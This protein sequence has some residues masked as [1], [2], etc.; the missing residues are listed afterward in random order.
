[1]YTVI[2]SPKNRGFRVIWALEEMGL[3]YTVQTD[4]PASQ[5]VRKFNPL[6]KVPVLLDGDAVITD[7]SAILHYL[8]DKH[9][10][11]THAPGTIDRALQDGH[12]HFVLDELDSLLWTAAKH[13]FALPQA[14]RVP[15]VKPSLK[16]EWK[17][18]IDR[19]AARI[20]GPFLCGDALTIA[21]IV[22]VHC[23]GW[24]IVAKFPLE[25]DT[26]KDWSKGFRSRPAYQKAATA[27]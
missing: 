24:G 14:I 17:T 27:I 3:P 20:K 4:A 16:E 11:L 15:E 21:D 5:E 9:G 13:S 19:L 10:Q 2:G 1:M 25:N 26:V 7:S 8:A 18:S 12:L 22:A 6:G 23:I